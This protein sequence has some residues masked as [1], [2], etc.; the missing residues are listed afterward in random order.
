MYYKN[1]MSTPKVVG[2]QFLVKFWT[3]QTKFPFMFI[4]AA[5]SGILSIWYTFKSSGLSLNQSY[6]LL[7]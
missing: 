6:V 5:T 2:K 7:S 3:K 1:R 4:I